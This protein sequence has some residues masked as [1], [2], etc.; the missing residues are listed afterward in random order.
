MAEILTLGEILVE[1]MAKK[2]GQTFKE[3][4]DLIGPFPSGAPAIF[5]DQ[6]AKIGSEAGII[7]V[8]GDDD[9]G[10]INYEKLQADGVDTSKIRTTKE[11]STGVAFVTYKEDGDR[12]FIFHLDNSAAGLLSEEDIR[13]ED[14]DGCK[15]FHIMGTALYN[16]S[17]IKAV[18]KAID[19]CKKKGIKISFDPNIRKEILKNDEIKKALERIYEACDIFMPSGDEINLFVDGEDEKS[20]VQ[21]ILDQGKEYVVIKKG[22]EGCSAYSKDLFIKCDPLNVVEVDPTG[23]GD[24][25]G[26]TFISCIN[27]GIEFRKAVAY[28]NVAGALAVTKKGP[29]AGNSDLEKLKNYMI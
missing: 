9:F 28:A 21:A 14:F 20:S 23:A 1:V 24:C 29:M 5:I 3:T 15:Y 17:I 26:G 16:S 18:D 12:D 19:I 6:V 4:G 11:R 8:I 27:Q 7:S 13:E 25:F 22:S 2:V 10:K